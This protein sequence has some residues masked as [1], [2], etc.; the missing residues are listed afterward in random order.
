MTAP[1]D[2]FATLKSRRYVALLVLAAILGAPVSAAAYW[3]LKLTDLLQGW[4]YHDIPDAVGFDGEPIWWPVIP[5][6]VAGI[7]VALTIR[8][9]PGR[10]GHSPA[11]GFKP[12][13]VALPNVLPGVALAA[14]A[15]IGLGA[16]I[17]P[18][19][20]LVALGGGLA[21]LAVSLA[22]REIPQ[23]AAAVIAA[24]GS[25]AAISALFGSPLA[26]AFLLMEATGLGGPL[27]TTVLLPGL[28]ASGIGALVFI[29]FDSLTGYGTFS[30]TIP[31]LPAMPTPTGADL[32]YALAAGVV[33]APL[34][35]LI[36]A[37]ALRLRPFVD[38][39]VLWTP[40]V[41]LAM[42]GLAIAYAE[43]TGHSSS[44][45]LFSGQ[46]GL[47]SLV[48]G[49]A[50]YTVG[51]L[52]LLVAFKGLA[53]AG[54]LSSFR[55]GPTFPALYIGAA[56]GIAMSHLP[57]FHLI[58]GVA[59]GI[60]AMAA[61][62]LRLPLTAVLV[63]TLLLGSDGYNAVPLSVIAAVVCFVV[64]VHLEPAAPDASPRLLQQRADKPAPVQERSST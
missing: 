39:R 10:G 61:G 46:S 7:V 44:D 32:G 41:G 17:G 30:L 60:S 9:L 34:C 53:Y 16:V 51:A 26:S 5:L 62:M 57:G 55:G 33:A 19:G 40:L 1:A 47:P 13:G 35:M 3:F 56:G 31:N 12:G 49:H 11:D 24:T 48:S 6:F 18:E 43:A 45:V 36:R 29:G 22:R 25:F 15:S 20:P 23:P 52:L 21:Y 63:T 37:G 64:A 54:A 58:A 59:V 28:L 27:A 8:F 50:G 14:L 4:T 42:A 38:G 2:P